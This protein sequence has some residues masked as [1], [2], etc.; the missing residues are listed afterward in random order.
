MSFLIYLFLAIVDTDN[1]KVF[2]DIKMSPSELTNI[3]RR[4]RN[5]KLNDELNSRRKRAISPYE[6]YDSDAVLITF[7]Y[8]KKENY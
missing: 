2:S 4:R 7:T 8:S 6:F 5:I 3:V 1:S